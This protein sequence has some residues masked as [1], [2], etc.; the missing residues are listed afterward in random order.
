MNKIEARILDRLVNGAKI[1][2]KQA[3]KSDT[4]GVKWMKR[5]DFRLTILEQSGEII[6][7]IESLKEEKLIISKTEESLKKGRATEF[8][9]ITDKGKAALNVYMNSMFVG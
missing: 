9:S 6:N 5:N 2:K 8:F 7:A 1:N 3:L 4:N